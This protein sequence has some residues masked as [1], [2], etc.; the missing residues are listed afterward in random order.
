MIRE[1]WLTQ[2]AGDGESS[3]RAETA[4]EL[5][6][7]PLL[8]KKEKV[9]KADPFSSGSLGSREIVENSTWSFFGRTKERDPRK[10][11]THGG[12]SR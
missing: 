4:V 12:G 2:T 8:S 7:A 9:P 11:Q 1:P 3:I 10:L 6:L 5:K